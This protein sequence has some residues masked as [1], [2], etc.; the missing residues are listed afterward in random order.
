MNNAK[1]NVEFSLSGLAVIENV[2]L[3]NVDIV[4]VDINEWSILLGSV[5]F[6]LVDDIS[7]IRFLVVDVDDWS[8]AGRTAL[9]SKNKECFLFSMSVSSQCDD[10]E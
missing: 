6:S 2:W 3:V 5:W 1:L 9:W 8:R 7:L 10:E 4:V